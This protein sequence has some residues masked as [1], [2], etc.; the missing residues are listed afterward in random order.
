MEFGKLEE[1]WQG[2]GPM[3]GRHKAIVNKGDKFGNWK[4]IREVKKVGLNRKFLCENHVTQQ[5][6]E[7]RLCD[8]KSG[9]SRGVRFTL[10][11]ITWGKDKGKEI[12]FNSAIKEYGKVSA[13]AAYNRYRN[14]GWS[15]KDALIKAP[16]K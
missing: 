13:S 3:V 6:K 12:P 16:V 1:I 7:I 2:V 5:R 10:V 15:L 8:L 14:L 11:K 4:I 9:L